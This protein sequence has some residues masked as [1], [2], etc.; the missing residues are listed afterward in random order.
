M[1]KRVLVIEPSSTIRTLL[2]IYLQQDGH[3]VAIFASNGE[4]RDALAH[5][6]F[7]LYPPDIIF[8]AINALQ[9]E[10]YRFIEELKQQ[11][12]DTSTRIIAMVAQE[13]R[14]QQQLHYL[15]QEGKLIALLKPFRIQDARALVSTPGYALPGVPKGRDTDPRHSGVFSV[16]IAPAQGSH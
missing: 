12:F 4:A 1:S 15:L 16:P 7:R 6:Q 2:E 11:F 5:P 14:K 9:L 13:E 3:M 8:V 10:S